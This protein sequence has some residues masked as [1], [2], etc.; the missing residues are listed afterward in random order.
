MRRLTNTAIADEL[1][2][3]STSDSSNNDA[4]RVAFVGVGT[5]S[6]NSQA[7]GSMVDTDSM[8][9]TDFEI[10]NI[11]IKQQMLILDQR[12]SSCFI[13]SRGVEEIQ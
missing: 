3:S 5:I 9:E 4:T 7:F 11:E 12:R 1:F 6:S 2:I 13:R 8:D 10:R